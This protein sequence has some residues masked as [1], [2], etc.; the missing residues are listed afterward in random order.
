M[1]CRHVETTARQSVERESV[2]LNVDDTGQLLTAFKDDSVGAKRP[3]Y[4]GLRL[5]QHS[6]RRPA[7]EDLSIIA[8]DPLLL[9]F[10]SQDAYR[11]PVVDRPQLFV[12]EIPVKSE[13]TGALCPILL[14]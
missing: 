7:L 5:C 11:P 3:V 12:P 2:A 13:Y 14:N 10:L 8:P 1:R 9:C 4:L 6:R